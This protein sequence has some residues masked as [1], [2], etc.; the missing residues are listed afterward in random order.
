MIW[1]LVIYLSIGG[2]FGIKAATEMKKAIGMIAVFTLFA[3]LW[4]IFVLGIIIDMAWRM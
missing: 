1:L 4:P 2:M 3:L